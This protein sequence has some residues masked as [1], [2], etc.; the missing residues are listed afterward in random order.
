MGAQIGQIFLAF[1][2]SVLGLTSSLQTEPPNRLRADF[3]PQ[4]RPAILLDCHGPEIPFQQSLQEKIGQA[5]RCRSGRTAHALRTIHDLR[6]P[7]TRAARGSRRF[8]ARER[9]GQ[10]RAAGSPAFAVSYRRR[11]DF[12]ALRLP[13]ATGAFA[14]ENRARSVRDLAVPASG[15]TR[16]RVD[17]QAARL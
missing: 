16:Y 1:Q 8:G 7:G 6:L 9:A 2:K 10:I 3:C 11:A 12:P 5:A 13:S 4:I 14:A 15:R 17:E